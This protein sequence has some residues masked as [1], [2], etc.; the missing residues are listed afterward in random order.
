VQPSW[1]GLLPCDHGEP[2]GDGGDEECERQHG[3]SLLAGSPPPGTTPVYHTGGLCRGV[4][5]ANAL[6]PLTMLN[7]RT[8]ATH[9][10][11]VLGCQMSAIS[12][13]LVNVRDH[14]HRLLTSFLS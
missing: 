6:I 2:V 1:A 9:D 13:L 3:F 8:A 11:V 4:V 12:A 5:E 7:E 14:H 10:R